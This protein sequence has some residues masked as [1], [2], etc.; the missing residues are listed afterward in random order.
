MASF[1][2]SASSTSASTSAVEID[3]FR[4]SDRADDHDATEAVHALVLNPMDPPL[5]PDGIDRAAKEPAR[6]TGYIFCSP[7]QRCIQTAA[8]FQKRF[9]GIIVLDWGLC[10]VMHPRVLKGS[11]DSLSLLND[12]QVSAITKHFLRNPTPMPG[13]ETRG[14]GGSADFRYKASIRR[15]AEWCIARSIDRVTI[16]SHGDSLQALAQ[17]V[18]KEIY[19]TDYCCRMTAKFSDHFEFISA[20]GIGMF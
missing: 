6:S 12:D 8:Q 2:D 4:H 16:V 17:E 9:G 10:E 19:Q 5:S 14:A 3:L 7:F 20:F 18:G 1:N 13:E 11:I 15:I